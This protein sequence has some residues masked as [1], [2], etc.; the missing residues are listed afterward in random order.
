MKELTLRR[1]FDKTETKQYLTL[2]FEVPPQTE[3]I[4]VTYSYLRYTYKET[5]F[6]RQT[7]ESNII[8]LGLIDAH[9]QL[10]G[11][12][13]SDRNS[14]HIS[15]HSAT[16]GYRRQAIEEGTWAVALGIYKVEESVEVTIH[17]AIH[18]KQAAWLCGDLHMHT[19]NSDG[20]YSTAQVIEYA[21]NAKLDFIALTDHN[22]TEQNKE[23]GNPE[24]ITVLPAMEYTNYQGHA[25]FFF[26]DTYTQL[27]TSP[28]SNTT[29]EMLQFFNEGR[30]NG[31]TICLNHITD[32]DCPWLFGFEDTPY[33]LVEIWNGFI[34]PSDHKAR[35]WWH[36][37]LCEGQRLAAVAGSDTHHIQ[38]GRSYGCPCNWVYSLSKSPA[39]ILQ[40]LKEGR[41]FLASS[42]DSALLDLHLGQWGLGDEGVFSE[43]LEGSV[44]L[45]KAK[46]GD[47]LSLIHPDG[48]IHTWTIEHEGEV[49]FSFPV[50]KKL[51][52]RAELHRTTLGMSLL[53]AMTNPVYLTYS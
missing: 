32:D 45:K 38:V 27:A 44:S 40:A 20:W 34:K 39:D 48:V 9:N 14:V 26:S 41:S 42:P 50:E 22:N 43:G 51:F 23:I 25:N 35:A 12:S 7:H 49:K 16:P 29:E 28:L 24:G 17:L 31:A 19:L 3:K 21:R 6:E 30:T 18:P 4:E 1:T 37:R 8:D 15:E 5:E 47:W 36:Q 46:K 52:Y 13:G 10:R 11:W 53:E 2:P 33:D